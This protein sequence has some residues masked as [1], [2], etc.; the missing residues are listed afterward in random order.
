LKVKRKE[1]ASKMTK[2]GRAA[3]ESVGRACIKKNQGV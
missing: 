3:P 1:K 2:K